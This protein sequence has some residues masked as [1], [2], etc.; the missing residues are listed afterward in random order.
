MILYKY[1]IGSNLSEERADVV[2]SVSGRKLVFE[3][4]N[5]GNNYS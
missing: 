5:K 4:E 3:E 2:R 1:K